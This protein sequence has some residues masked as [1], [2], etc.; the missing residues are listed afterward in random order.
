MH[1]LE[2]IGKS[3]AFNTILVNG[4]RTKLQENEGKKYIQL[5]TKTNSHEVIIYQTHHY[6]G[7]CWFWWNLLFYIIS[8]FGI[9][10]IRH[11]KKFLS[12]DCKLI[13]N[14]EGKDESLTTLQVLPFQNGSKFLEIKSETNQVEEITNIQYHDTDAK[15]KHKKMKWAKLGITFAGIIA[16]ILCL[17]IL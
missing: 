7:K 4:K 12:I 3:D 15:I 17:V 14:T 8:I 5:D 16:A 6:T 2:I 10:D 1:K 13:I 11:N 9:F